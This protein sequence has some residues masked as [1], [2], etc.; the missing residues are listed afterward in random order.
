MYFADMKSSWDCACC[1]VLHTHKMIQSRVSNRLY[2]SQ[3]VN[4]CSRFFLLLL[5]TKIQ[6][7]KMATTTAKNECVHGRKCLSLIRVDFSVN[8]E[9]ILQEL[10]Q[11]TESR[12]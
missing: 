12:A 4:D 9:R 8:T 1:A 7:R 10:K 5:E 3:C 11:H 6:K 2:W